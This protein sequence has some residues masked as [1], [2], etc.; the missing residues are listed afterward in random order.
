M[1]KKIDKRN[2]RT[3]VVLPENE[4]RYRELADLL[5]QP[6]FEI[7]LAGNFTFTN[8]HA[9]VAT[10]FTQDDLDKEVKA[11][12][13]FVPEDRERVSL[14]IEK[15]VR[16]N[17]FDDH[18]YTILRKDGTTFPVLLYS[19][20]IFSKGRPVG[21][22]GIVLDI[23]GRI[24]AEK[25]LRESEERWQFAL[26]GSGDGIWDWNTVTDEIYFSRQW[27]KI[28]GYEE[29]EISNR[30][31]EWDKRVH[32]DDK[33]NV[34]RILNEHLDGETPFF[35]NEH[36]VLCRDGTYTWI[37]V[38]GKVISRTSDGKPLRV[39][40]TLSDIS[41][42]KNAERERERLLHDLNERVKELNCL[43]G[44]SKIVDQPGISLEDIYEQMV[45][46][47]PTGFQFPEKTCARMVLENREFKT[48]NCVET[49]WSQSVDLRAFGE[50]I[51]SIDVFYLEVKPISVE[52][53]FLDEE[54]TLLEAL[55]ERL[56]KITERFK[57]EEER[58]K[59]FARLR[60]TTDELNTI[61][62]SVGDGIVSVDINLVITS[63]NSAFI[64]LL[65]LSEERV[66]GSLCHDII[67]CYDDN[68]NN[69]CEEGCSL[70]QTLN[71]GITTINRSIIRHRD[72]TPLMLEA[73]NS[74]LRSAD[75]AII[76]AVKSIRDVTK[77]A[78][79]ERMKNEF[80]STVSHELRTPLTS[81]RGYLDLIIENDAGEINDLQREF[82]GII[83]EN[84]QRLTLLISELLDIEKIESGKVAF[85]LEKVS[86]NDLVRTTL[87]TLK[88]SADKK[89]ITMAADISGD[90]KGYAD[91]DR[92]IQIINNL[93][94]NAIKFTP[95]GSVKV[96]VDSKGGFVRIAVID[97]GIG[98][99]ASDREKLFTKFFRVK[100][101]YTIKVG[102]TGLGLAIV[103][104]IVDMH[105]GSITVNSTPGKGSEFIV[106][107][108]L[109]DKDRQ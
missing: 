102:G 43:Y 55:A 89:G 80:I 42:R 78:E 64:K 68:G 6:I 27:K 85:N 41:E 91:P 87:K 106:Q 7:D 83:S 101:N 105:H 29:H 98:I 54:R 49:R 18:E 70:D 109:E 34:Y 66:I 71:K 61:L 44:L 19:N 50:K 88:P 30:R 40:G 5:P 46:L 81:I 4:E 47:I 23:S 51:G 82:L 104:D 69:L 26:E 28:L 63:A 90:I 38:R 32:P 36:R 21:V 108:P 67:E 31:E 75:G 58:A 97:T 48:D 100:N 35:R 60:E 10:G 53:I 76:G 95:A 86:F 20:A 1:T 72:G 96:K 9:L 65:G 56:G 92:F 103:K 17:K 39:I 12:Q 33:E 13:L 84:T 99:G 74:P 57:A 24:Q 11:L 107:L 14:N 22:R 94:S 16:G 93:V 73:I 79:I 25:A 2:L 62:E 8:R 52:S 15:V 77:E 3:E 37:L 45:H 59:L